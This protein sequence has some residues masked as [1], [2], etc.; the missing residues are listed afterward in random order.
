MILIF[1]FQDFLCF[2]KIFW[3]LAFVLTDNNNN[4]NNTRNPEFLWK[5]KSS[6]VLLLQCNFDASRPDS[7]YFIA[8]T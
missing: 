7:W 6:T 2:F 1:Y 3:R 4:N 8:Y 5:T